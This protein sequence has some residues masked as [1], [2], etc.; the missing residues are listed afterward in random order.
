MNTRMYDLYRQIA[1]AYRVLAK[2]PLFWAIATTTLAVGIGASTAVFTL[3]DSVVF[4]A[5]PVREPA[6]LVQIATVDAQ[7]RAGYIAS[8]TMELIE[9]A[10]I[11]EGLCGFLTPQSTVDIAGRVGPM[12]ALALSGECF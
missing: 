11:F 10:G 7:G 9:R 3:L 8:T 4:R 6:G 5:L 2:K 1:H 12:A